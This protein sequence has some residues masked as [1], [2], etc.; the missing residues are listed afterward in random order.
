MGS[1]GRHA[2]G[3]VAGRAGPPRKGG[4]RDATL[5]DKVRTQLREA[6]AAEKAGDR[7]GAATRFA[8]LASQSHAAGFAVPATRFQ[9]HAAHLLAETDAAAALAAGT[10]AAGYAVDM[11]L[12][13]RAVRQIAKLVKRL[14]AGGHAAEA[15][16]L[17]AAT[18]AALEVTTL[19][20][21][22]P[23]PVNRAQRRMLP[24]TC[25]ECGSSVSADDV[26]FDEDGAV[27]P[28]CGAGLL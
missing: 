19:K 7:A 6:R 12:R 27:C 24:K 1:A 8:D 20:G 21:G 10:T 2:R 4:S 15:E 28:T 18:L 22:D 11:P 5:P 3:L 14:E 25:L 17:T 9:L 26:E 16:A 23:I 13:R